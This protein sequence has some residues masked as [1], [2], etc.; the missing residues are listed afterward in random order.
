MMS[1]P[2]SL[3]KFQSK[4][5]TH[6]LLAT[7]ILV[8]SVIWIGYDLFQVQ[9]GL[10]PPTE[11]SRVIAE[12]QTQQLKKPKPITNY[13]NALVTANNDIE[14]SV[15]MREKPGATKNILFV[16]G[17]GGGA[18]VWEYF[19]EYMP[20]SYNLYALSWRGHYNSS[21]VNDAN[22]A[23][24]VEDQFV[25]TAFIQARSNKPIHIIGH[26]YGASTAVLQSAASGEH[27]MSLTLL[28]P[29]VPIKY[30]LLQRLLIPTIAPFLW[31]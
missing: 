23:D 9:T 6:T 12:R 30:T 13:V 7:T 26:S 18:W 8:I 31:H 15:I 28:A 22:T 10:Q 4:K 3:F 20:E 29:V 21:S 17:A 14:L 5:K 19:F 25:A 1:K 2:F 16:H 27:I 11:A 24:Y